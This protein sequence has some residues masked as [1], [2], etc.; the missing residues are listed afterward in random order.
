MLDQSKN[1]NSAKSK[2]FRE[3][4]RPAG[5]EKS[6]SLF[7]HTRDGYESAIEFQRSRY[8]DVYFVNVGFGYACLP[9]GMPAN[10]GETAPGRAEHI[11]DMIM[12]CR[13]E[14]L[15]PGKYPS[16]WP[17]KG[18]LAELEATFSQNA[19]NGICCLSEVESRWG[20][21]ES[22]LAAITPEVLSAQRKESHRLGLLDSEER[23]ALWPYNLPI[24]SMVGREW[25]INDDFLAYALVVIA[26]RCGRRAL[27][28]KYIE[29][30]AKSLSYSRSIDALL[31]EFA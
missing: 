22:L 27:V 20:N 18:E 6:K 7:L 1:W 10:R 2:V 29:A 12:H 14:Q 4:L 21:P 28:E 23:E 30:G 25:I 31:K 11:L 26:V 5:Y 9:R 16:E 15:M 17:G 24:N 8:G 13:L 19:S 3:V